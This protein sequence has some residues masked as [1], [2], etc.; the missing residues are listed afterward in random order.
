MR[1]HRRQPTRLYHPW[2]SLSKNTGVGCHFLLWE[3]WQCLPFTWASQVAVVVK[4]QP[5]SSEG[6]RDQIRSLRQ[7]DPLK[8]EMAT[9]FNILAWRIPWTEEP[10]GLQSMGSKSQTW[11]SNWAACTISTT[12]C[13][14][15]R[16]SMHIVHHDAAHRR[17]VEDLLSQTQRWRNPGLP[18]FS[19]HPNC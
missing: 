13:C 4:N 19:Q 9:H 16:A 7:E 6:I 12:V 17:C 2:D 15:Q 14:L 18:W 5:A 1:P 3:T 8:E 11:L 10:S